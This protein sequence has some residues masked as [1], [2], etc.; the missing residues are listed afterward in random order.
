MAPL[1][2]EGASAH[3]GIRQM[4]KLRPGPAT[5][6]NGLF[7]DCPVAL[8]FPYAERGAMQFCLTESPTS[9]TQSP[10]YPFPLALPRRA[11]GTSHRHKEAAKLSLP[12]SSKL[13]FSGRSEGLAGSAMLDC[14]VCLQNITPKQTLE[15]WCLSACVLLRYG[16]E[17]L[18]LLGPAPISSSNDIVV[19]RPKRT[20]VGNAS[21]L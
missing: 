3:T 6:L 18:H 4:R 13:D 8:G 14:G 7:Q 10:F 12:P 17:L 15:S 20:S 5:S 2:A 11:A 1:S 16:W 9:P 19:C 21:R